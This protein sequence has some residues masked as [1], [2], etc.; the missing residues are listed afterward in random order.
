MISIKNMRT[1]RP[2]KSNDVRVDRHSILGN[3]YK[4]HRESE[5]D[6]VCDKYEIYHIVENNTSWL[7]KNRIDDEFRQQF[8]TELNRI[9]NILK[10]HGS[11]NLFCWCWPKRCHSATIRNYLLQN[12]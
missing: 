8:M 3:P 1:Q 9:K 11:V 10:T 4:M 2:S 6:L 7:I 12:Q 5:R